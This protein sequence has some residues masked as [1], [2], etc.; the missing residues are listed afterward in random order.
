MIPV[1]DQHSLEID[2]VDINWSGHMDYDY[3][4]TALLHRVIQYMAI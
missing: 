3:T 4:P 1:P 2:V